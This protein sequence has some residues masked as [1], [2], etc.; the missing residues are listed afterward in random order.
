M[1]DLKSQVSAL[2]RQLSSVQ[3]DH[4]RSL[5]AQ[6]AEHDEAVS[7]CR[8]QIEAQNQKIMSLTEVNDELSSKARHLE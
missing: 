2:E 8:G 6:R 4:Q 1:K 3:E 7:A 5:E